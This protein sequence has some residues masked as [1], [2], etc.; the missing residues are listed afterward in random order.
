[1]GGVNVQTFLGIRLPKAY[2]P[3]DEDG[4]M[5]E[6]VTSVEYDNCEY[7]HLAKKSF[8]FREITSPRDIDG[9]TDEYCVYRINGCIYLNEI[10][11]THMM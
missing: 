9:D 1:M 4:K 6:G 11:S 3:F 7:N 5:K 2:N 10:L 8:G